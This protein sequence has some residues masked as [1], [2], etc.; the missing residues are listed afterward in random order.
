MMSLP[1]FEIHQQRNALLAAINDLLQPDSNTGNFGLL[2]ADIRDFRRINTVYG[3]ET[4][5]Q[6]LAAVAER[7]AQLLSPRETP[8]FR[9][10]NDEFAMLVPKLMHSELLAIA[11][12]KAIQLLQPPL[13]IGDRHIKVGITLG[14]VAS[15]Q[16]HTATADKLL[17]MAERSLAQAR[18]EGIG[19]I[20]NAASFEHTEASDLAFEHALEDAITTHSLSV[21]YQPKID[22][23]SHEARDFEALIRWTHPTLGVI[24]PDQFLPVVERVGRF[25][26]VTKF[27]LHTALRNRNEWPVEN[28]R[29]AINVPASMVHERALLD[30]VQSAL[31]IWGTPSSALTLEITEGA[32]I[33]DHVASQQHLATLKGM[34]TRI[35]IDD[36]GTGYSS[37]AYFKKLP[38]SELKIDKSFVLNLCND[39]DDRHLVQ[40]IIDLAHHFG[41][42]VVAEGVE[43]LDTLQV[44]MQLNCDCVQGFHFA[45]AM[46]HEALQAWLN[47]YDKTR[48]FGALGIFRP[49]PP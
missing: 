30:M 41:L 3:Y 7:L 37:L 24:P 34:G 18:M 6:V 46:A 29:V 35:S 16:A 42:K 2:I 32:I 1:I 45:P 20:V 10:G 11:A 12:N 22:L 19:Y 17:A 33:K 25:E 8:L 47:N 43:N 44:L 26:E 49:K 14:S 27:V 15:G 31:N 9:I 23:F 28:A 39:V 40:L 48:Y 5:D 21:F 13:Q 36:F 4:G 38:A